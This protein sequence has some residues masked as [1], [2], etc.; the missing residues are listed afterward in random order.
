MKNIFV[1]FYLIFSPHLISRIAIKY[2]HISVLRNED[3]GGVFD[4]EEDLDEEEE[5]AL[6][7]Y[8]FADIYGP[9]FGFRTLVEFSEVCEDDEGRSCDN[10]QSIEESDNDTDTS[11]EDNCR[12]EVVSPMEG[13]ELDLFA[14]ERG[15]IGFST[16]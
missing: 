4:D 3:I 6:L 7:R 2:L 15:T 10:L 12:C 13:D 16:F 9:N 14:E 11:P 8:C 5:N 1:L